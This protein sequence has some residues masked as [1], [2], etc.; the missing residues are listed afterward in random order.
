MKRCLIVDDSDVIRKVARHFVEK[1]EYEVVDAVNADEALDLC[2]Q[3]LPDVILLDW[4]LPGTT[5]ADF[6]SS[7]ALIPGEKRPF[8]I[9]FTT[10]YDSG[11][12]RRALAAGADAY[13]MKPFDGDM[14][15]EKFTEN[16]LAAA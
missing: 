12:I 9:Y 4:I 8:V 13:L 15:V 5:V 7:L 2:K 11:E 14:L 1:L 10:E 6:L 16:G 3:D